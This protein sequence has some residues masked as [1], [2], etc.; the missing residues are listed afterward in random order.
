VDDP[1]DAFF[2]EHGAELRFDLLSEFPADNN[3]L[4]FQLPG[5]SVLP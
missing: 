4:S 1:Q 5:L 3:P 2:N